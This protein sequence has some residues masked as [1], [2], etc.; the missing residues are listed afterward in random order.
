MT[1]P[2]KPRRPHMAQP[3]GRPAEMPPPSEQAEEPRPQPKMVEP[4]R[5]PSMLDQ[6]ERWVPESAGMNESPPFED[7]F[8]EPPFEPM[9]LAEVEAVAPQAPSP[10]PASQPEPAP[11][12]APEPVAPPVSW[13][14]TLKET[15]A[16]MDAAW[17]AFKAAAA[18]W[19]SERMD[20]RIEEDGW[21]RKQMLAHITAWHD[22]THD[23]LGKMILSGQPEDGV[24]DEDAFNAR[25]ARQAIGRTAG[26]ILKEMEMTYNRL[27]RQVSRLN[28]Q[29]LRADDG[30]AA[31]VI[32]GNTYEHYAEHAADVYQPPPDPNARRR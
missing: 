18:A 24:P 7:P 1:G 26:E 4:E 15:F 17:V 5:I 19:P 3:M 29:Q 12:P 10:E 11:E 27:R 23:R 6:P 21:S 30:W 22:A 2:S 16:R 9:P 8:E 13:P 14:T 28:E 31:K 20:E 32:A 25:I